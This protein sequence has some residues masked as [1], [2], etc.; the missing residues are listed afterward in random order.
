MSILSSGLGVVALSVSLVGCTPGAQK[1]VMSPAMSSEHE[2]ATAFEAVAR[3]LDE[4]PEWV[5]EMYVVMQRH[6][7]A[8]HRILTDATRDLARPEAAAEVAGLLVENPEAL[9]QVLIAT[10]DSARDPASRKAI[11][12]AVVERSTVM[13]DVLTDDE[14][15]VH[16]MMIA[17]VDGAKKKLP[18]RRAMSR[19]IGERANTLGDVTTDSPATARAMLIATVDA[20]M[21]KPASRAAMNEAVQDRA[22]ALVAIVSDGRGGAMS[23]LAQAFFRR[24]ATDHPD[25][26]TALSK[27]GFQVD[28]PVASKRK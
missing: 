27:L 5:D 26:A 16:A 21:R 1:T 18:A 3:M 15:A 9:R 25:L 23:K 7:A 6:P 14:E 10:L 13:G 11:D 24:W 8:F 20:A 22:D 2:R 4:H 12:A 28:E 17:T 19:A